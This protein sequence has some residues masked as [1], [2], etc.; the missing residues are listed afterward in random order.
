MNLEEG[1][2]EPKDEIFAARTRHHLI[3]C[4]HR[5]TDADLLVPSAGAQARRYTIRS[6]SVHDTAAAPRLRANPRTDQITQGP[7]KD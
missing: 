3:R 6:T 4:T 2:S 5:Q 1:H 7:N